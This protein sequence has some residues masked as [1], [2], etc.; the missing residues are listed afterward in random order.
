[1]QTVKRVI[2]I[3]ILMFCMLAP[4]NVQAQTGPVGV[5]LECSQQ[6]IGIN[7]HPEQNTPVD[8]SCVVTNTG[9]VSETISLDSNVEGNSFALSLSESSFEL[10]A[11][12]DANFV[13][14]FSASDRIAVIS[15][16]Y[17]I[18]AQVDSW[19]Q[20]PIPIQLPWTQF[21]ATSEVGGE[22]S[23]L[24]YSRMT[25]QVLDKSTIT[26]EEAVE[27]EDDFETIQ[28]TIFND[29]NVE[30]N[31]IVELVNYD[32]LDDLGISYAFF[33]E[34][35][36]YAGI[37]SYRESINPGATS[38]AGKMI[39]GIDKLPDED[40]S[41]EIELRAYSSNDDDAEPIEVTVDVVITGGDSSAL[42]LDSVS[43][44]DLKLI[45]MAG[46]GLIGVIVLL[47]LISRLTKKATGKQKVAAKEAKRASKNQRKGRKPKKAKP[48]VEELEDDDDFDFDDFDDDF[49][50][51]DL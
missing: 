8:V 43:S 44:S 13:A 35:P 31:I 3:S 4:M 29:G 46:G 48:V 16:D 15:E 10:G 51:D 32:E 2:L 14:T 49:D 18:T 12:E 19:G 1:M 7:V 45:G 34:S 5:E 21:G 11:G 27:D 22:V 6:T 26:I 25:F 23:S 24:A 41:F 39:F 17:N 20:D 47:V 28:L 9:S 37:D 38:N 40:I 42:G 33:S 30:D 50:F 36:L